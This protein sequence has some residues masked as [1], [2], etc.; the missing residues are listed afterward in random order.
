MVRFSVSVLLVIVCNF[1]N[2]MSSE[3]VE[4]TKRTLEE[5]EAEDHALSALS[6]KRHTG[7]WSSSLQWKFW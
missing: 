4:T 7:S 2:A 1:N 6:R 3:T 5:V